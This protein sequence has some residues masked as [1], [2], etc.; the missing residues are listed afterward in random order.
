MR[1]PLI[2]S[3]EKLSKR[4]MAF[5]AAVMQGNEKL[6]KGCLGKHFSLLLDLPAAM[7]LAAESGSTKILGL[8]IQYNPEL[9]NH[10]AW[11]ALNVARLKENQAVVKF[12]ESALTS[13]AKT[14][15]V[16]FHQTSGQG[17]EIMAHP[18]SMLGS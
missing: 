5:I 15:F 6:V 12:L 14:S 1:A 3:N 16:V 2:D 18:V 10:T 8:L 17:T 11:K 7:M 13:H 9:L 4:N